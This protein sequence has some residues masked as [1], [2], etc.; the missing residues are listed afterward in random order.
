[1]FTVFTVTSVE[2]REALLSSLVLEAERRAAELA[3]QAQRD[4]LSLDACH[5]NK[6][7]RS[8]EWRSRLYARMRTGFQHARPPEAPTLVR[9]CVSSSSTLSVSFQEPQS[10]NSTVV[11]KY[12]VEW[13]CRKDFSLLAGDAVLD[14]LQSLKFCITGLTTGQVYFVRVSAYNMKGWGPPACSLPPSAAP[15]NWRECDGREPKRRGQI[16]A[17]EK[18]LQQVRDTH[19]Q[20]CSGDPSKLQNPSRKQ[21]V[22]RSLK[23]LFNSNK[24]IKTLKRGVYLATV[25]YHR[26]SLLLTPDDHIPIVEVDDCF[27]SSLMQDFLWFT[28]LSCM[29]EDVRW[30]RQSMSVS[31]SS[32]S[33]LQTRHKMLTAAAHMQNLLG[34]HNLGRVH[35]EPIKDRHGNVLLVTVRELDSQSSAFSGKWTAVTKLQSQRK[36]LST[37]EEP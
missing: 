6:A 35:F 30:L 15:S 5:N 37:P 8:W 14:N 9:L 21:S 13:S 17:M 27:G 26:D 3:A 10:L 32:S 33:T 7:L 31:M 16:E 25:L 29:W 12:K 2:S 11:T 36:S 19:M 1:M 18:L 28:K 24:F 20:Y 4:G 23:H 22:S 34:T